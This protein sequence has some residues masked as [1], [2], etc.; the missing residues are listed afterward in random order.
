MAPAAV[1]SLTT[2]ISV[3]VGEYAYYVRNKIEVKCPDG[4]ATQAK[5]IMD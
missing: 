1:K 4:Y 5:V 3:S 2:H